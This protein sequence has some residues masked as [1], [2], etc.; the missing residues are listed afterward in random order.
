MNLYYKKLY[1][2]KLLYYKIDE[3]KLKESPKNRVTLM[4]KF[5]LFCTDIPNTEFDL[6]K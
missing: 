2:T 6:F 1:I 4:I 5:I 3:F